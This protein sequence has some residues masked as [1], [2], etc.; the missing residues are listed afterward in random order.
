M[1]DIGGMTLSYADDTAIIFSGKDWEDTK[2]RAEVG[3]LRVKNWL[4]TYKLTLNIGKTKYIAFS[5]T[6]ASRPNFTD[7]EKGELQ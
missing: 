6:N 4:E 5:L 7:L 1:M 2:L 3:L